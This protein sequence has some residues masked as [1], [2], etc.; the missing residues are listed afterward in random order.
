MFVGGFTGLALLMTILVDA[1]VIGSRHLFWS[2]LLHEAAMCS[3][4]YIW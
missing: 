2:L 3:Y 1:G 4:V